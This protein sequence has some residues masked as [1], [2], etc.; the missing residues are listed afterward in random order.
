MVRLTKAQS[1]TLQWLH[2]VKPWGRCP[3]LRIQ[4]FHALKKKGLIVWGGY[5]WELT[6]AGEAELQ[7]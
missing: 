3:G 1:K 2:K 5:G 4:T 6:T 7:K